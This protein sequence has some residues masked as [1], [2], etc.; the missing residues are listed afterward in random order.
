MDDKVIKILELQE[1]GLPR[2][3]ISKIMEY[4]RLDYMTNFM[5]RKGFILDG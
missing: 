3:E 4:K 1:Q 2:K 5:K